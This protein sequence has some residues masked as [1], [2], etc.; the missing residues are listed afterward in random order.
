MIVSQLHLAILRY[1]NAVVSNLPQ[2]VAGAGKFDLARQ[3]VRWHYQWVVIHDFLA[4]IVG[5]EVVNDILVTEGQESSSTDREVDDF[6]VMGGR[7]QTSPQP[8]A[9]KRPKV[10]L[11]FFEWRNQPFI[12]VEFSVAAYRF[13]HSMVRGDY[14]LNGEQDE[15]LPI[16]APDKHDTGMTWQTAMNQEGDEENGDGPK[17]LRGFGRRP[18]GFEIDWTLFFDFP[19]RSEGG[20]TTG[21]DGLQASRLID[22]NLAHGLADLPDSVV[23]RGALLR[24]LAERNL[25]RG[26]ALDLPSGQAVA[27]TMGLPEQ[28]VLQPG[29]FDFRRRSPDGT[30]SE[31]DDPVLA[32]FKTQTPL[33]YYILREAKVM[34]G[35]RKLGPVG[36]R[37]VAEVFIG[38]LSGDPLSYLNLQPNWKPQP[39]QFGADSSGEFSIAHLLD[40]VRRNDP[41]I[42]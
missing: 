36:G 34:C 20:Y 7:N 19:G 31:Y 39:N 24:A 27:R 41:R 9:V 12:P 3:I 15:E 38:L 4:T 8:Q 22:T 35:G 21:D 2:D 14:F 32:K 26:R 5:E 13:G 10:N 11:K 1:H 18:K 37:L 29:D 25:V 17:D 42:L 16:F 33:W 30:P 40:F 23:G 28:L 6:A